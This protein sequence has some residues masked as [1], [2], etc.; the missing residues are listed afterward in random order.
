MTPV[1]VRRHVRRGPHSLPSYRRRHED[2]TDPD[3]ENLA[4]VYLKRWGLGPL[5]ERTPLKAD[6]ERGKRI[7]AAYDALP[8][9][10]LDSDTLAAYRQFK[11]EVEH[12]YEFL[13]EHINFEHTAGDPYPNSAAMIQDVRDNHTLRVYMG[14]ERHPLLG[15]PDSDGLSAND[16]FRA[17]HDVFGHAMRGYQFGPSGEESAWGEHSRMF[18]PLAQR[19]MTTETRGQ[20][21]W[22]NFSP[23]NID[24]P[25]SQREFAEQKVGL[26]PEEFWP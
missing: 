2:A 8:K 26:L 13:K 3:I 18:S 19:A 23:Q 7:A 24:K 12:Q 4:Q 5:G 17:V 9:F 15:E 1:R 11:K 14:G 6:P 25:V 20:N 16:K 21:S 10:S 22:F